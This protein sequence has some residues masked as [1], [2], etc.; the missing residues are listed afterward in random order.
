MKTGLVIVSAVLFLSFA[1]YANSSLRLQ[2]PAD[3]AV[4]LVTLFPAVLLSA[5]AFPN[6]FHGILSFFRKIPSG[7]FIGLL[8]SSVFLFTLYLALVPFEG[9]PKG[10]DEAAYLFQSRILAR[11]ELTAP[12]P[13]VE[14]P[15]ELFP[16]RHFIFRQGEW[17]V[18]YTMLHS[19]LLAPFTA[20]GVSWLLGPVESALS[21]LG[22]WLLFQ[23]LTDDR[24]A[25]LASA[26]MT[27]SPFFLFMG[28]SHMAH[29]S[30]LMFVT[31]AIYFL[32][33]GVQ[34]RSAVFQLLSGF[35]LGLAL[36]T[37]PYPVMPWSLTVTLVLL[38]KL[39]SKALPVLLRIGAGAVLPVVVFLLLN[40]RLTGNPFS[41]PYNLARGGGLIGFGEGKAWFPE[42]GDNAHT[43]LRG[44]MNL[45]KQAGTGSTILLGWPF[46]SLIPAIAAALEWKRTWPLFT[47][48]LMI[49]PFM[50][51]HYSASVDYGPRHYFTALPAFALLSAAGIIV[52]TDKWGGRASAA[53]AGLFTVATVMV[54]IPDG[55]ALRSRP[56]QAIDSQPLRIARETVQPPAVVFMEAS[57]NGYP[58]IMSGLLGTDPFLDGDIIF[59]AHQTTEKDIC[60][61]EG[62]FSNRLPYLFYCREGLCYIEPWTVEL[63]DQLAAERDMRPSW[64]PEN[65]YTESY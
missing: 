48:V 11:G 51:I 31:W 43:P 24:T 60:H 22:A 47:A 49:A 7:T 65:L 62:I 6:I 52:M 36:N 38:V 15:G 23:R 40:H 21:L 50:F 29:N 33:R 10:G 55:I 25:R 20:A 2:G 42:Y 61:I 56:W 57:E 64:A 54:Y 44:L 1:V 58:N 8:C 45:F 26:V 63:S 39:R 34:D 18:M 4:Q 5:L 16:F 37:K 3:K 28:G 12:A 27:L 59:C 46:L 9:I 41:P 17:F 35:L 13:E 32:V 53:V 30:N 19:F 14:E